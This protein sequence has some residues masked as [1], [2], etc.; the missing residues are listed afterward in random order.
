MKWRSAVLCTALLAG[1]TTL[2][3][4]AVLAAPGPLLTW[5][6]PV[7]VDYQA[8]FFGEAVTGVSCPSTSLC[9]AVDNNGDVVTSTNPTGGA[10]DWT[11]TYLEPAALT[12]LS[13]P[14]SGLCVAVDQAGNVI[15]SSDPTG[16]PAAWTVTPVDGSGF[17]P[18]LK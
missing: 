13:C 11:V 10:A 17:H 5:A 3:G 18:G 15:T 9:V 1:A 12:G 7:R 4:P 8:P 14:T 16:G 6:A 2:F